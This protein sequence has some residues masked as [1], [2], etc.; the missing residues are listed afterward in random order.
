MF[1][2]TCL[3]DCLILTSVV[4]LNKCNNNQEGSAMTLAWQGLFVAPLNMLVDTDMN[5]WVLLIIRWLKD[6]LKNVL[7]DDKLTV[8]TRVWLCLLDKMHASNLAPTSRVLP[9]CCRRSESHLSRRNF[10]PSGL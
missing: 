1:W 5:S 2:K 3:L 10:S 7:G 6:R 8:P 4:F 9:N